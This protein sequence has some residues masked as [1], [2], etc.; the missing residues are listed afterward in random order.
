MQVKITHWKRNG[1]AIT[2]TAAKF[3]QSGTSAIAIENTISDL[4]NALLR[5]AKAVTKHSL[6]RKTSC[7]TK[8][9]MGVFDTFALTP[10]AS[11][12][13][14]QRLRDSRERITGEDIFKISIL[15]E[16]NTDIRLDLS[17]CNNLQGAVV[18]K[19]TM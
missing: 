7:D 12:L 17:F 9:A 6:S 3:F 11:V 16:A 1:C 15:N 5:L 8:Q 19:N 18:R 14:E 10:V 4:T 13:L 2:Q